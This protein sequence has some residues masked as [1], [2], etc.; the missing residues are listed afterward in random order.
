[1]TLSTNFNHCFLAFGLSRLPCASFLK[2]E[3]FWESKLLLSGGADVK[4]SE[5][6]LSSLSAY[7]LQMENRGF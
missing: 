3:H 6:S 1:M 2:D 4:T 5:V 7:L